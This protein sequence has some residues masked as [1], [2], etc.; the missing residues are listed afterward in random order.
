[1]SDELKPMLNTPAEN[2]ITAGEEFEKNVLGRMERA[3]E[4]FVDV[5][6]TL[7]EPPERARERVEQ[8]KWKVIARVSELTGLSF[9]ADGKCTNPEKFRMDDEFKAHW[10]QVCEEFGTV[11]DPQKGQT[12]L[13]E[14][15]R[16]LR[17]ETGTPFG[18][19]S[20]SSAIW[21]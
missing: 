12:V 9:N 2:G 10:K 6:R 17:G 19:K 21:T 18:E 20:P 11:R 3:H 7:A 5:N 8:F 14:A 13:R 4:A 1:M 15:G 16:L